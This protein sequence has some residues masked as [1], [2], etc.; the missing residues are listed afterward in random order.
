MKRRF[1]KKTIDLF[2]KLEPI[3]QHEKCPW[4][5]TEPWKYPNGA[6][7][8]NLTR[9]IQVTLEWR[10]TVCPTL[11]D[12]H[13]SVIFARDFFSQLL[14]ISPSQSGVF[15]NGILEYTFDEQ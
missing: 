4:Y 3:F 1:K 8:I 7:P 6:R 10:K 5:V 13:E 2:S 15:I 11:L 14:G 9:A 12:M